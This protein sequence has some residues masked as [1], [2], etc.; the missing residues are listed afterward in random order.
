MQDVLSVFIKAMTGAGEV[1]AFIV[2]VGTVMLLAKIAFKVYAV[3]SD[4]LEGK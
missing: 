4:K 1:L 3:I 2:A